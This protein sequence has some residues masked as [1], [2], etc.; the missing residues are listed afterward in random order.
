MTSLKNIMLAVCCAF[1]VTMTSCKDNKA[2]E[3]EVMP[4]T[5]FMEPE[6]VQDYD[7]YDESE[8]LERNVDTVTKVNRENKSFEV[9]DQ[10]P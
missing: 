10:V 6:S 2:E 5:E 8:N 7:E 1:G 3:N 9:K 4:E